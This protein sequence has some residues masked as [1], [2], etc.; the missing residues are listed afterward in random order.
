MRALLFGSIGTIVETSELQ[1]RAFNAAFAEAELDWAWSRATYADLLQSSGGQKRIADAARK[2]G[3]A[4]DP[5]RIHKR[6][7]EIFHKLLDQ[8]STNARPGVFD[9][10]SAAHTAGIALGFVTTTS[11]DNVDAVLRA[12]GMSAE[13]FA[14]IGDAS[15]A[16]APKPAPD[17]YEH[18]LASLGIT[19]PDA[20]AIE[21]SPNGA[22]SA[23]A[24][25]LSVVA[26]SGDMHA[27]RDFGDVLHH[28]QALDPAVLFNER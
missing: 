22:A 18:A 14:F 9:T 12:S 23:R 3:A 21:D 26:F 1:R 16:T 17:I 13:A 2:A 7:T 4:V 8:G 10:I 28:T 11:R 20:L 6:K 15:M 5:E 27:G 24:A 25:G 19:A